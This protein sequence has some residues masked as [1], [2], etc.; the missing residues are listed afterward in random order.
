[1]TYDHYLALQAEAKR[2]ISAGVA[3]VQ[4]R[5]GNNVSVIVDGIAIDQPP[6]YE[7]REPSEQTWQYVIFGTIIRD[8]GQVVVS[9]ETAATMLRPSG[10]IQKTAFWERTQLVG[11]PATPNNKRKK[12]T[13]NAA[14]LQPGQRLTQGIY[15]GGLK[16]F[17]ELWHYA[18]GA[19]GERIVDQTYE[20]NINR[21]G[22]TR[23]FTPPGEE[24]YYLDI[25]GVERL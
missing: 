21:A 20:A 10:V 17:L 2:L 19:G 6:R 9:D 18:N 13:L 16:A 4:P 14:S 15:R 23:T 1:M 7:T 25:V 3:S 22:Y 24:T 12:I 5:G 8:E 11:S